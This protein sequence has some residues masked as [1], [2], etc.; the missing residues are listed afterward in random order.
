MNT[1]KSVAIAVV[2]A[3]SAVAVFGVGLAV[4]QMPTS[5]GPLGGMMGAGVR[6]GDGG[7]MGG[8]TT[9]GSMMASAA[10]MDGDPGAMQAMHTWMAQS[11]G[12]HTKVWDALAAALDVTPEALQAELGAGQSLAAIANAQG[13][14]LAELAAV[15]EAAMQAGLEE[16]V[17]DGALTQAQADQMLAAM[18]GRY[19]WM[20]QHMASDQMSSMMGPGFGGGCHTSSNP[21]SSG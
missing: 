4:A 12:M 14:D 6:L 18:A 1:I 10:M 21:E 2:V 17:A 15:L 16:A 5:W 7:M 11:G 9:H 8:G 20:I 19:T 13:V 3:L